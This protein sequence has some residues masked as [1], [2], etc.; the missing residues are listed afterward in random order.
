M[1]LPIKYTNLKTIQT[2]LVCCLLLLPL[3]LAPPTSF[4]CHMFLFGNSG[5]DHGFFNFI[6]L[7][8]NKHILNK[9]FTY[10]FR[11]MI[12]QSIFSTKYHSGNIVFSLECNTIFAFILFYSINTDLFHKSYAIFL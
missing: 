10:Q 1:R 2:F 7:L 8:I 6:L 5:C 12:F 3:T 4:R 11:K 9:Q